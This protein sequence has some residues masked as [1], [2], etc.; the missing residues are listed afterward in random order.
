LRAEGVR[1][2]A[3]YFEARQELPTVCYYLP[4]EQWTYLA[5]RDYWHDTSEDIIYV[6]HDLVVNTVPLNQIV[7]RLERLAADPHQ[8]EVLELMIHEQY[9]YP[10]YQAYQPDFRQ[11][12]E[13]AIQWVTERGYRPVL[14]EEGYLGALRR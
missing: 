1:G 13:R 4:L 9:F 10:D 14:F 3:G 12:V 7:P 8:S 2:L 6:R 5:G 11:K